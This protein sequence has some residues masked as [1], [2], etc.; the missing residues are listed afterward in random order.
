MTTTDMTTTAEA[1]QLASGPAWANRYAL[2]L[3]TD[4]QYSLVCRE[5]EYEIIPAARQNH[6]GLLPWSPLASGFLTGKYTQGA[7]PGHPRTVLNPASTR[8]RL[9]IPPLHKHREAQT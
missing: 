2:A 9:G 7:Q 5:I 6:I 3:V 8:A 1:V 4:K